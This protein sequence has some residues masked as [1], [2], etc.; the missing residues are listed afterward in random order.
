MKVIEILWDEQYAMPIY[1]LEDGRKYKPDTGEY[2]G[3][4]IEIPVQPKLDKE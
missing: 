4:F 3:Y 2:A 1:V